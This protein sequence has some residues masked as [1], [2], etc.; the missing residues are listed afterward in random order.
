M[1]L[2]RKQLGQAGEDL[3]AIFLG[4]LGYQ[5]L[6]RNLKTRY[7]EVDILARDHVTTVIVEVKTKTSL[8]FGQPYE[9]VHTKKQAKL[10]LL[11]IDLAT[12]NNWSDYRIDVVSVN[13]TNPIKPKIEHLIAA[14]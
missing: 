7:G 12:K 13:M 6:A 14:V 2:K 4:D 5:I 11:A 8:A 3:A 1:T 10:R 9:M